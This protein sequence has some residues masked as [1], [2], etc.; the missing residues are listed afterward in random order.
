MTF[1]STSTSAG[2]GARGPGYPTRPEAAH[3]P[4]EEAPPADPAR[5]TPAAEALEAS[6][7]A[8]WKFDV[9][10]ARVRLSGPWSEMLG[11]AR[12]PVVAGIEELFALVPDADRPGVRETFYATLKGE[13]EQYQVVHCVRTRSGDTIWVRASGRVLKRDAQ[14]RARRLVGTVRDISR[15][16]QDREALERSEARFRQLT[17]IYSDW[18]WELDEELRFRHIEGKALEQIGIKPAD[19]IGMAINSPEGKLMQVNRALC[20]MLG[21]T[22]EEL[23]RKTF[24]D[25]THPD[26]LALNLHLY[27]ETLA[28]RRDTYQMDK[29][30][31]HKSGAP[32]WVQLNVSLVRDAEGRPLQFVTQIQDISARRAAQQAAEHLALHDALTG[33]ANNRLLP[34]RIEQAIAAAHRARTK[35]G[36]VFI[37]LDGCKPI[38]DR[39]GHAA[40]DHLLRE[41]GSRLKAALREGDTVARTG[42]DE[43]AA[44]VTGCAQREEFARV[45]QRLLEQVALPCDIGGDSAQV[46]ASI[47]IALYPEDADKPAELLRRADAAMYAS[48]RS[49]RGG[50][51]F[52][53]ETREER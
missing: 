14:G 37:D 15:E 2:A 7:L 17:Q 38:N 21:Y 53:Q 6:G 11:D 26:D 28:G 43:F 23:Q 51:R 25:I 18:F 33:L 35:V 9:G 44:V 36:V 13:R 48:K 47:G 42:G 32:V 39:F 3:E 52:A 20:N 46:S 34:D 41:T 31:L 40:G 24:E 5:A 1:T 8:W 29:R 30:Y 50:F 4:T 16:M 27:R 22:R 49:G 45:A 10:D 12:V 19:A